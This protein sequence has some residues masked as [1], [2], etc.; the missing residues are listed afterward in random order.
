MART[1]APSVDRPTLEYLGHLGPHRVATGDLAAAGIPGSVFAPVSGRNLPVI[2]FGHGWLQPVRRYAGT[3][4]YL[5]S[6]GFIAVAP[7]TERG[8]VPS[9]SGLGADLSRALRAVV[10]GSLGGGVVTGDSSRLGAIGHSVGG[11]AA[12]LAAATDPAIKAVVTVTAVA[13][14]PALQ[15]AGTVTVPGLHLVGASDAMSDNAGAE[16]A[17]SWGGPVQ[18]REVKGAKHLGLSE[19]KHWTTAIVGDGAEK[20]IQRATRTLA[21]AFLLRH[22][23]GQDQLADELEAKIPGTSL[24][25]LN[26]PVG[27]DS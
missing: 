3:L 19:G 11:S 1:S 15:A 12:V 5:A 20:R 24:I 21:T 23:G 27:D 4:R 10:A 25:D 9:H 18:L 2:A 26:D 17:R 6:W 22:I 13:T 16:F 8:P 14:R 7:D